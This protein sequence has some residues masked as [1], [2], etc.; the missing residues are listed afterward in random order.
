MAMAGSLHS[1]KTELNYP[2]CARV[3]VFPAFEPLF[4]GFADG[5]EM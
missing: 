5:K 1:L 4:E 3:Y 2:G